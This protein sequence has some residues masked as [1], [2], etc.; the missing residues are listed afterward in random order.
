MRH[1]GLRILS[2]N[3]N[4]TLQPAL[5]EAGSLTSHYDLILLSV[6]AFSL[7]SAMDGIAP[8]VGQTTTIVPLLNGM[9]HLARLRERFGTEAIMGGVCKIAAT[10]YAQGRIVQFTPLHQLCY[11][12]LDDSRTERLARVDAALGN[13]G[14]DACAVPS[15]T[16]ALWEKWILLSSLGGITCLM[17]GTIGQ[18]AA[19]PGGPAFAHALVA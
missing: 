10:L 6:K 3:G 18:V 4:V 13:A 5:V 14:F 7:A 19:A 15:I 2:P 17:R 8:A 12:E 11:G 9:A 16:T 1:N